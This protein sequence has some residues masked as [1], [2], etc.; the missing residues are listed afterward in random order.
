MFVGEIMSIKLLN[1][2]RMDELIQFIHQEE[3]TKEV[4]DDYIRMSGTA[5]A[6]PA[7]KKAFKY[8]KE[9]LIKDFL[10]KRDAENKIEKVEVLKGVI[11]DTKEVHIGTY[12]FDE[13]NKQ[14][15]I[16]EKNVEDIYKDIEDITF[17]KDENTKVKKSDIICDIK[18]V[19]NEISLFQMELL[20]FLGILETIEQE[21]QDKIVRIVGISKHF[22]ATVGG[23]YMKIEYI[24]DKESS[25]K[26]I[27]K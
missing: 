3:I 21:T 20:D 13:I 14:S 11:E 1:E 9:S 12:L 4:F 22:E 27:R 8:A 24:K 26:I 23:Y 15:D 17:A 7:Q 5:V 16:S 19:Y 2:K 10:Y 18:K 6:G 25:I